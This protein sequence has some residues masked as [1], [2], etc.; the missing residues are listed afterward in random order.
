[1]AARLLGADQAR[2]DAQLQAHNADPGAVTE[3]TGSGLR[4]DQAAA[5][6]WVL[7]E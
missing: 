2:L 3:P 7:S 1:M 4:L 5:A 6:F